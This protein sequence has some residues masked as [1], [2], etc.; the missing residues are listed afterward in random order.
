MNPY[1]DHMP[2]SQSLLELKPWAL[3]V[4]APLPRKTKSEVGRPRP[5]TTPPRG[6][7]VCLRA[8]R[9]PRPL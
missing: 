1:V 6:R 2:R 5:A 4:D 9:R 8:L 3:P 7:Q